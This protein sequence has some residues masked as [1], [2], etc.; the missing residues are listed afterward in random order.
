MIV[1]SVVCSL[2][3]ALPLLG[4]AQSSGA[5]PG[6]PDLS[7]AEA[8]VVRVWIPNSLHFSYGQQVPVSFEV[9]EA[10]HVAVFRIDGRGR[11]QVLWPQRNSL[12]TAAQ[13]GR[14][15][16]VSSPYS[17]YGAFAADYEL[18]QGMVIAV[19]SPDPIELS[20]FRRY[21][22]DQNFYHYADLQRPYT[23][24]VGSIV[25]R[26]SQE[27]LYALDSPYDFDVAFY[28]SS[29]GNRYSAY[30][31]GYYRY[32]R[33]GWSTYSAWF[34]GS[35][36]SLGYLDDCYNRGYYGGYLAYCS[37]W[38]AFYGYFDSQWCRFGNPWWHA[39]PGPIAGTPPP[40]PR[41]SNADMIDT[42]MS[43]PVALERNNGDQ[44]AGSGTS[45]GNGTT[46]VVVMEPVRDPPNGTRW[47]PADENEAISLP[48]RFRR[49]PGEPSR[50]GGGFNT[51]D[52]GFARSPGTGIRADDPRDDSKPGRTPGTAFMPPVR[53][54][55]RPV[56][57][58]RDTDRSNGGSSY[59]AP[60]RWERPTS[61]EPREPSR[62]ADRIDRGSTST[63][64]SSPSAGSGSATVAPRTDAS[65][66][67]T[68]AG[69]S[70]ASD[71]KTTGERKPQ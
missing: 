33:W 20:A 24:G 7:G 64:S 63:G 67:K 28:S 70:K 12:Q 43:R 21:R 8:P 19:A 40:Q 47:L 37:A 60:Q 2:V 44:S 66:T 48:A 16:R 32:P 6:T 22:N 9:S 54:P 65:V 42:V 5:R 49:E 53:E 58:W 68:D 4:T 18:G 55:P 1:R 27:I 3:L 41:P 14:E 57:V 36:P 29:G 25:D 51:R 62:S 26:L 35:L 17:A 39:A 30:C 13:S 23:G 11:M 15:Y 69:S 61:A 56:T 50:S 38:N 10:S 34:A 46:K 59:S 45:G 71:A 52:E 31:T